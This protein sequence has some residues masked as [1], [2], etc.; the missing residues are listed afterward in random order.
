ME[1][2]DS[3]NA[4]KFLYRNDKLRPVDGTVMETKCWAHRN[5]DL[6]LGFGLGRVTDVG[7]IVNNHDKNTKSDNTQ[8]NLT[9]ARNIT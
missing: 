9:D 8:D 2:G 7:T 1:I 4:Y 3:G 6:R 5:T